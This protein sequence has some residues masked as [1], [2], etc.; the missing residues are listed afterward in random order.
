MIEWCDGSISSCEVAVERFGGLF[1]SFPEMEGESVLTEKEFALAR[2]GPGSGTL[3]PDMSSE[4]VV[5]YPAGLAGALWARG[6]LARL[7]AQRTP[8]LPRL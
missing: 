4:I 3:R 8:I 6:D 5:P 7:I 1:R 2:Q